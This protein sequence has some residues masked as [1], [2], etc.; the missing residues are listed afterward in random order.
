MQKLKKGRSRAR[1]EAESSSD[2]SFEACVP[3]SGSFKR[4]KKASE[5]ETDEV[6][7]IID[8]DGAISSHYMGFTL[9][10]MIPA[11]FSFAPS[12][13]FAGTPDLHEQPIPLQIPIIDENDFSW[14]FAVTQEVM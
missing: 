7:C 6:E 13:L 14:L 3:R 1:L 8:Q 2:E 9:K 10:E 5:I 12:V 11:C 4:A